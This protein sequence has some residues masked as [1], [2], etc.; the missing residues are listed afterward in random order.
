MGG[1]GR[2]RKERKANYVKCTDWLRLILGKLWHLQA[3]HWLP[4]LY[5]AS[6]IRLKPAGSGVRFRIQALG[7]RRP[8]PFAGDRVVLKVS[9]DSVEK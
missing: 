4:V 5:S 9:L 2:S 7:K 1:G 6:Q 3:L 8:P